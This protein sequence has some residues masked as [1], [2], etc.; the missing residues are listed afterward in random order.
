MPA[1]ATGRGARVVTTK[2]TKEHEGGEGPRRAENRPGIC[3]RRRPR[4]RRR[5][6]RAIP[7]PLI[8]RVAGVD[9]AGEIR[10]AR[11]REDV[12]VATGNF[13][14]GGPEG[15]NGLSGKKL[16]ADA[17]GPR[18]PIGGGALCGKDFF[19]ADRALAVLARRVAKLVVMTGV[20]REC[21]ATLSIFPGRRAASIASLRTGDNRL[22]DPARWSALFDLSLSN[23]GNSYAGTPGLS[24]GISSRGGVALPGIHEFGVSNAGP[25]RSTLAVTDVLRIV[26]TTL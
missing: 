15:D 9:G 20:A 7:R 1:E 5:T 6:N 3:R 19:K 11:R 17:Y 10:R 4:T 16:V 14:V 2:C 18:V 13:D 23:L 22:L 21:T 12:D 8:R 25:D 24:S 26:P